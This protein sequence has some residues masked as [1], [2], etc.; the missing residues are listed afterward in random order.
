MWLDGAAVGA[1][2]TTSA[3]LGAAPVG[4]MQIGET[5]TGRTYDV[6]LDDAAFG[7]SRIGVS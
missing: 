3:N 7:T 5:Q 1:L 4:A 2:T 6:L